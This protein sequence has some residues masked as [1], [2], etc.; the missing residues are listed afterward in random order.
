[1]NG[2][3]NANYSYPSL[4]RFWSDTVIG[5]EFREASK[6]HI[7]CWWSYIRLPL[8]S[9]VL[10]IY[11]HSSGA[12]CAQLSLPLEKK[13]RLCVAWGKTNLLANTGFIIQKYIFPIPCGKLSE[14]RGEKKKKTFPPN[15]VFYEEAWEHEER[16]RK[17]F[18]QEGHYPTGHRKSPK[19]VT[20]LRYVFWLQHWEGYGMEE[21]SNGTLRSIKRLLRQREQRRTSV[22]GRR[23][24]LKPTVF[25]R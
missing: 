10:C 9:K 15:I 2:F 21:T 3:I 11:L 23:T 1:M 7:Y 20:H 25:G 5:T 12:R 6:Y 17:L 19:G 14:G 24:Y 16:K 13:K 18:S 4:S 22:G 8:G